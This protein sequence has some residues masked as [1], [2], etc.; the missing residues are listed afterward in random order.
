[1]HVGENHGGAYI[2]EQLAV[3][4]HSLPPLSRAARISI[5]QITVSCTFGLYSAVER[6]G[7]VPWQRL[8]STYENT[9]AP[10]PKFWRQTHGLTKYPRYKPASI[11]FLTKSH[12]PML[13]NSHKSLH[14]YLDTGCSMHLAQT[15][16]DNPKIC[17]VV[18]DRSGLDNFAS[19]GNRLRHLRFLPFASTH[20]Q[21]RGFH[22]KA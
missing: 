12:L 19:T 6:G 16:D 17:A 22:W 1:M 21:Q 4:I 7:R 2:N 5:L 11:V 20:A 9:Q 13:T 8:N 15:L 14:L 10:E 18:Q 3:L